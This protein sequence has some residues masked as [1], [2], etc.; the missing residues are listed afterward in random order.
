VGIERVLRVATLVLWVL[1]QHLERLGLEEN[2]GSRAVENVLRL[3]LLE[4]LV[5]QTG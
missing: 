5:I 1:V 2:V 4:R 3:A